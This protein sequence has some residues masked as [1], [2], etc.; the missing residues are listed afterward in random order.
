MRK[1]GWMTA[2]LLVSCGGAVAGV[3]A[4]PDSGR[5]GDDGGLL[6]S[7][8]A[9]GAD[10][11]VAAACASYGSGSDQT[12]C[13]VAPDAGT[14]GYG[15][16]GL[17]SLP[18]GLE[19]ATGT[20]CSTT[21]DPCPLWM[22]YCGSET[23]SFYVCACVAGRW[24][25]GLCGEGES[26]CAEPDAGADGEAGT[27]GGGDSDGGQTDSGVWTNDAGAACVDID[28][29]TYDTS[30]VENIDCISIQSGEVCSGN[31]ACGGSPVSASEQA[32]YEQATGGIVFAD[33]P[34][35][36]GGLLE[37]I[38]GTCVICGYGPNQPA[39]CPD[40]G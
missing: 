37:C 10:A 2:V 9:L 26:T 18:V 28:L 27:D 13:P 39:G 38:A 15:C 35:V 33:C 22:Q 23:V 25:C 16:Y 1:L 21:I 6:D 40:A 4:L 29:S 32:R 8:A 36:S 14:P 7:G 12:S 19:C 5:G 34:C 11:A 30:C 17:D 31:C 20:A 3:H 24:A